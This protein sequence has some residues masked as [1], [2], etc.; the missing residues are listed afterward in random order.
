MIDNFTLDVICELKDLEKA[1]ILGF[2]NNGFAK[3]YY[4]HTRTD[5]TGS[6]IEKIPVL[7]F[8]WISSVDI[9]KSVFIVDP[10]NYLQDLIIDSGPS[11]ICLMV[12]KWLS[13]QPYGP[14]P[15]IGH[16]PHQASSLE[17]AC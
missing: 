14:V 17:G 4:V 5:T 7:T 15:D 3:S 1:L 2:S 8:C 16:N 6:Y 11:D 10:L 9:N 13:K 12:E